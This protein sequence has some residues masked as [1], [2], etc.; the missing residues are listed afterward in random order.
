MKNDKHLDNGMSSNF[1][2]ALYTKTLVCFVQYSY[3]SV[4]KFTI[5]T[6][7]IIH[8]NHQQFQ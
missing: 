6:T 5:I 8:N 7:M 2:P 4:W 1:K 3:N